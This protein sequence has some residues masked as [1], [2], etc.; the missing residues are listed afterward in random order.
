ML[1][2]DWFEFVRSQSAE[3]VRMEARL[4]SI[5]AQTGAKGQKLGA[6]GHSAGS[7]VS[8]SVLRL[9]QAEQEVEVQRARTD[10]LLEL[11]TRILY[12]DG[13]LAKSRSTAD[14]DCICGYYL[15]G[16]SWQEVA[17]ELAPTDSQDA[18]QWCKR[19][20]YRAMVWMDAVHLGGIAYF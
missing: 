1:A 4:E 3:L 7:D 14:A 10:A 8:G 2:R 5:R 18:A 17:D 9:I 20:A 12:G 19:R 15:M 13:G 16:L 6:I 11:A